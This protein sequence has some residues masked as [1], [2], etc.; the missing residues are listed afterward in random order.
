MTSSYFLSLNDWLAIAFRMI[1]ALFVGAVI[2]WNRQREHKPAGLRTHMLVSLGSALYV[3][4][5]IYISVLNNNS[6]ELLSR[7]I[8]GSIQGVATGV[9]FLGAGEIIHQQRSVN[10]KARV[11]GLT[12][13]AAI[14][15]S[16][17]LGLTVGAGLYPI[18]ILGLVFSWIVIE[19][20]KKL[21]KPNETD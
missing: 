16:S 7:G 18:A 12:S 2:G 1:C 20:V 8:Q 5:P 10:G 21:E 11:T 19:I 3:M 13:A 4:I 6:S 17:A 14:W 15:V 9:C